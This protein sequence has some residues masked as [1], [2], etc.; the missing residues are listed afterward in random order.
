MLSINHPLPHTLRIKQLH[1]FLGNPKCQRCRHHGTIPLSGLAA[2]FLVS[3]LLF[4]SVF[5]P[6][7]SEGAG[8]LLAAVSPRVIEP[9]GLVTQT[10]SGLFLRLSLQP[11]LPVYGQTSFWS[12]S[13]KLMVIA[14][15]T[16]R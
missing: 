1:A 16:I 13:S 9:R 5:R 10:I 2:I 11:P 6:T 15:L 8:T 14:V 3:A 12:V 7:V 4:L